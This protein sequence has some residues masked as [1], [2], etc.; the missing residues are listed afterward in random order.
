MS[1]KITTAQL[2]RAA[3]V[4]IRQSSQH[5]VRDHKESQRLQYGLV[6]RAREL[7]F[8]Q[9]VIVDEDL[10]ISGS[11]YAERPG[12]NRLLSAVCEERVGAVLAVEVSRLARNSREWHHLIDL[13]SLANAVLLDHDGVYDP[14]L[15]NDRLILGLKGTLSEFETG[16]FQQRA[17]AAL[18]GMIERGEV[19]TQVPVGYIRTKDRRCEKTP[20]LEVQAAIEGL[21]S[22][23]E[24]LGTGRQVLLWYWEMNVKLPKAV[25]GTGGSDVTWDLP[26]KTQILSILKNPVYAGTFVYGRRRTLTR[27]KD[28]LARK[29]P[30]HTAPPSEWKTVIHDHHEGYISWS[31]FQRNQKKLADNAAMRGHAAKGAPRSGEAL[32]GGLLWCGRCHRKLQVHYRG[33]KSARYTCINEEPHSG[34]QTCTRFSARKV[35]RAVVAE[36]LQAIQPAGVEAAIEELENLASREDEAKRQARLAVERARYEADRAARQFDKA[37]PENRL[38]VAEL[39]RRW[40]QR[41]VDLK[42]AEERLAE[43][44]SRKTEVTQDERQRFLALGEELAAA[45]NHPGVTIELRKRIVRAVLVQ[46]V[47]EITDEDPPMVSLMLHWRGGSHTKLKVHKQRSG[48]HGRATSRE[49]EEL[50]R[51]LSAMC[52]D[53]QISSVLNRLG[54]KTGTGL[55]WNEPR[56]RHFRSR[57]GLPGFDPS[58]PRSWVNLNQAAKELDVCHSTLRLLID[59]GI[60]PARQ[61]VKHAPWK[62]EAADLLRSEVQEAVRQVKN[63]GR[64]PRKD[65]PKS[66]LSLFSTDRKGA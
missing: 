12:F 30:G 3:Y 58:A 19:L 15:L 44:E 11:G 56:V 10:G 66:Q 62:I 55:T 41:L 46:I 1:E 60:L 31:D 54:Y 4:Y 34:S 25:L 39:E 17:Q 21:F 35:D 18:R 32:L 29:S 23:F 36:V 37:E 42:N 59:R 48:E 5:Q 49:A 51:D 26:T 7:G 33:G 13:C 52:E 24:E 65:T 45:W 20:D 14:R 8:S 2:E 50:I 40:N 64:I 38:V 16:L 28:G 53:S 61:V 63:G 43:L 47:A 22:K 9:T 57:R 6:D 27:V